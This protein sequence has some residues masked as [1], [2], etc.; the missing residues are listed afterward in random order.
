[1]LK[2]ELCHKPNHLLVICGVKFNAI[3]LSICIFILYQGGHGTGKTGNLV[4]TFSRQGK[5]REF[6]SDTGKKLLTQGKYLTVIINIKSMFIFFKIPN[7]ILP[8]FA[9]HNFWLQSIMYICS[10]RLC[11]PNLPIYLLSVSV[12]SCIIFIWDMKLMLGV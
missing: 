5:H 1:M 2:C 4:L 10:H 9:R 11:V 8:R 7:K 3:C 6:C 12:Y